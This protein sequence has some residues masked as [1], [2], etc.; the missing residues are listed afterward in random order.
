MDFRGRIGRKESTAINE[1]SSDGD[2]APPQ[3]LPVWV[4]E[5]SY[6]NDLISQSA[7]SNERLE[8]NSRSQFV[9][10]KWG[11]NIKYLPYAFTEQ[12]VA[13]LSSILRSGRAINVNIEIMRAFVR[14]R[15]MFAAHP[16]L[17][18][19]LDS[20]EKKYDAQFKVVF[21]AIR[22]LMAPPAPQNKRP[23]GF[24]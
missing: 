3:A 5:E 17:A 4:N 10:L 16:D 8:R 22:E 20:L 23:I 2:F 6:K 7:I 11:K 1:L 19:K 12:C 18:R 14:L 15:Q 9:T 24:E 13:M 21:D